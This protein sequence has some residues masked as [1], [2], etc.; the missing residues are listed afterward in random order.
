MPHRTKNLPRPKLA[1][2][3]PKPATTTHRSVIRTCA[4]LALPEQALEAPAQK[5]PDSLSRANQKAA[6]LPTSQCL[7]TVATSLFLHE[8][9]ARPQEHGFGARR[10][11]GSASG[12][13]HPCYA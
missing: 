7:S 1:L 5:Q 8:P 13:Q 12:T 3:S 10:M 2:K 9:A 4:A 6:P 11:Q